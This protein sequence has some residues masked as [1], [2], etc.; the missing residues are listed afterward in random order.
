MLVSPIRHI[1]RRSSARD[2]FFFLAMTIVEQSQFSL[3]T[4]EP[5]SS[6]SEGSSKDERP[7]DPPMT[8]GGAEAA[9]TLFGLFAAPPNDTAQPRAVSFEN[10]TAM[11][12]AANQPTTEAALPTTPAP[13]SCSTE[14]TSATR[15][16]TDADFRATL[17]AKALQFK[18]GSFED[19]DL[20]AD[21]KALSAR[22]MKGNRRYETRRCSLE[23][24]FFDLVYQHTTDPSIQALC[25]KETFDDGLTVDY[26]FYKFMR[27]DKEEWKR[28]ILN[29][30]L[31]IY[32]LRRKNKR[33]PEKPLDSATSK[34]YVKQ[35]FAVLL[36]AP[37]I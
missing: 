14:I 23:D 20:T 7:H 2:H 15:P 13:P 11:V 24:E 17:L 18:T 22:A 29:R 9:R 35:L 10:P 32:F 33:N 16:S 31:I 8:Q 12:V 34:Q 6:E 19:R 30:M 28:Q 3:P 25:E 5:S 36:E 27:G 37:G 4:P 26:L 21:E 1:F